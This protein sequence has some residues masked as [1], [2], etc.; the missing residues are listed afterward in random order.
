MRNPRDA[1]RIPALMSRAADGTE[2]A[3]RDLIALGY[4]PGKTIAEVIAHARAVA[5]IAEQM[6]AR[7]AA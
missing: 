5:S 1:D 4:F 6:N 7:A 2:A 3:A